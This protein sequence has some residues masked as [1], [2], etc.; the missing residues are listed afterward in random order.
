MPRITIATSFRIRLAP[1]PP[2][3][4]PQRL[5]SSLP[6]LRRLVAPG[7]HDEIVGLLS[8]GKRTFPRYPFFQLT[9]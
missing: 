8:P 2:S 3:P 6:G 7:P 9:P 4:V 5:V 1:H